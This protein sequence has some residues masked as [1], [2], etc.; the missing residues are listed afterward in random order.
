MT[1]SA[2][3]LAFTASQNP[4]D[5]LML[6]EGLRQQSAADLL[7]NTKTGGFY[8]LIGFVG[9]LIT[10]PSITSHWF[11]LLT[12]FTLLLSSAL[13]R[14]N[15]FRRANNRPTRQHVLLA[16]AATILSV[17]VWGVFASW[18]I[19]QVGTIDATVALVMG[20]GAAFASG[21][22]I[23]TNTH[24]KLQL[25]ALISMFLPPL[26][27]LLFIVGD[28][29]AIVA[30]IFLCTY[31]FYLYMLGTRQ[32]Q[33]YHL[34]LENA[35]RLELQTIALRQARNEAMAASKA[36]SEFLAHMSHEIRTPL[37]GVIGSSELLATTEVTAEQQDY[38]ATIQRSGRLLMD[39]VNDILDFSRI[40]S[41]A[42][43]LSTQV[44]E[45]RALAANVIKM[46]EPAAKD[47]LLLL[48][49]HVD[50]GL[51]EC[52]RVDSLRVQQLMINLLTNAIKFTESGTIKLV[53]LRVRSPAGASRIRCEVADTGIGIDETNLRMIFDQFA[54]VENFKPDVRGVGLGL[55]I[56][57]QLVELMGGE[58][59]VT[60]TLGSG[61]TFW[62]EI[63]LQASKQTE[64]NQQEAQHETSAGSEQTSTAL[65]DQ[66]RFRIPAAVPTI[67]LVE[68]NHINR[69]LVFEYLRFFNCTVIEA[70]NGNEGLARFRE[71]QPDLILM[72]YNMPGLD[73]ISATRELR[74]HE[75]TA[76]WP[77]TPVV[78]LTAH[79]YSDAARECLAA[80]MDDYLSKPIMIEDFR[81]MITRWIPTIRTR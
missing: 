16:S 40:T 77:R 51:P 68:D 3:N 14:M 53:L 62:F 64:E 30:V 74:Q 55:S 66:S 5:G 7:S 13:M 71:N 21:T 20:A 44:I 24:R 58:I 60:S 56:C 76:R 42:L 78:A 49:I 80:G 50:T 31:L 57:K 22:L 46:V 19:Y 6:A 72:D 26:L 27:S 45:L 32:N 63:P 25:I 28:D 10:R 23:A 59:G 79:A 11:F 75:V 81:N 47:K 39:L 65:A 54:Q 15:L 37:N 18:I 61:S 8:Y 12:I 17:L 34:A 29:P 67:L 4:A 70:T 48:E 33:A 35:L 41:N 73:G 2:Q 69:R 38:L 1:G 9:V 52:V 43:K 36:K